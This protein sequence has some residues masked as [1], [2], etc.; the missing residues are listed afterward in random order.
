MSGP[1]SQAAVIGAATLARAHAGTHVNGLRGLLANPKIAYFA[2]FASL[3]GLIFGYQQAVLGQAFVMRSFER[4]FP[5]IAF[6][7]S[8]QGWLTAILQLSGWVGALVSGVTCEVISRKRTICG[9]CIWVILGTYLTAG[10]PSQE[11]LYAG[12]FFTGLGVGALS[13][14]GCVQRCSYFSDVC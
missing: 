9:S 2:L 7:S 6:S 13:A 8:N 3:G 1:G 4:Q 14:A 11:Y 12:R 10:A 5:E